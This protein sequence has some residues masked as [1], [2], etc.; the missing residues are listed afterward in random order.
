MIKTLTESLG[1]S[2]S[3]C[4]KELDQT[5]PHSSKSWNRQEQRQ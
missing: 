4:K 1:L 5:N 2:N 3:R